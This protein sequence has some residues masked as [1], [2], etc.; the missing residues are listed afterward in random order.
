MCSDFKTIQKSFSY[1][2]VTSKSSVGTLL[3]VEL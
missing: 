1:A 2:P 3:E